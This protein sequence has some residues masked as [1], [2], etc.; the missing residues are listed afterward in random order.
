LPRLS[1]S[2]VRLNFTRSA[3][4][5]AAAI[6]ATAAWAEDIR[7]TSARVWPAADYTRVTL[8]A[9]APIQHKLF[10]LKN[11]ERLVLDLESV[12]I[13]ATL[14]GLAEKITGNDPYVKSVRIGRFKP[15]TVRLVFDLKAEVNPQAFTLAPVGDYGHRLVLDLYPM[16]AIDPLMAL[17]EE[18]DGAIAVTRAALRLVD[19][20][21]DLHRPAA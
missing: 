13:T 12:N 4:L 17:L 10:S 3:L 8:E 2:I 15:G 20:A 18:R 11:P 16:Q 7:I 1:F 6:T 5:L 21:V 14:N 9:S 19:R